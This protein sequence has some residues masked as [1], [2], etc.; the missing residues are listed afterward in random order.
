[1]KMVENASP[2]DGSDEHDPEVGPLGTVN[3]MNAAPR[4]TPGAAVDLASI[5][6]R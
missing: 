2:S 4:V 5:E 3:V 1:M 6:K